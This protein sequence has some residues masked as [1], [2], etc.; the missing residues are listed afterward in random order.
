MQFPHELDAFTEDKTINTNREMEL[1]VDV[2]FGI[3]LIE[4]ELK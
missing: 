1:I 4:W 3:F 2:R